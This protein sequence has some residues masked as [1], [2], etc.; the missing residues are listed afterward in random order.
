M[1]LLSLALLTQPAAAVSEPVS[2]NNI[3]M[4]EVVLVEDETDDETRVLLEYETSFSVRVGTFL[5]GSDALEEQVLNYVGVNDSEAEFV[6][7]DAESAEII[8][9][10]DAEDLSPQ[11]PELVE[12][13]R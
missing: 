12:Y 1:I 6:S 8:Y 9:S 10:G 3:N 13:R 2:D 11:D 4:Q 5:F 7:L